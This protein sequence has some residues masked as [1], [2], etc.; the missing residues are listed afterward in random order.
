MIAIRDETDEGCEQQS[1]ADAYTI[2]LGG[3]RGGRFDAYSSG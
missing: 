3:R 2:V 1:T